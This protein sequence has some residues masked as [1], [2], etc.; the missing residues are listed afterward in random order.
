MSLST[1]QPSLL[2]TWAHHS[3][4]H[5]S[6]TDWRW[7]KRDPSFCFVCCNLSPVCVYSLIPRHPTAIT[8]H[9]VDKPSANLRHDDPAE[10]SLE[11]RYREVVETANAGCASCFIVRTVVD[12]V[13]AQR[14]L[15]PL[16]ENDWDTLRIALVFCSGH[17]LRLYITS[18][19]EEYEDIFADDQ[20]VPD[21]DVPMFACDIY[22][23][24][25]EL[26]VQVAYQRRIGH[27]TDSDIEA[28]RRTDLTMANHRPQPNSSRSL[29]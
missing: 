29:A 3:W 23:L 9:R 18:T 28:I 17:A 20:F 14:G 15:L 24:A 21:S 6:S 19:T 7:V 4:T 8:F 22:T 1:H 10:C 25:G 16:L 5:P 13:G 26:L 27:V 11:F 2:Y 12:V